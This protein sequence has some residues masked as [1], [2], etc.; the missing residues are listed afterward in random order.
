MELIHN[1][2]HIYGKEPVVFYELTELMK[3]AKE[4]V[5]IHT[6]Y[7]VCNDYMYGRLKEA[8]ATVNVEM[9]I[10]SVENGDNFVAS[11]DYLRH[12]DELVDTGVQIYEYDG[13]TSYHGKSVVIDDELSIIGSYNMDLRSTYV[14]TELMLAVQSKALTAQLLEKMD[15][16]KADSRKVIDENTYETPDHVQVADVP[17]MKRAAWAVVGFLL[18]PFRILV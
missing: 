17:W 2:T 6:P 9:L 4:K 7:A 12:K 14:D 1:P 13:G 10:N 5:I 8:S 15:G 11:S 18:Q 3:N 16:Y